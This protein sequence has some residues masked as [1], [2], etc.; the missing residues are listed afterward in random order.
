M[1]L[2]FNLFAG[3]SRSLAEVGENEGEGEGK[4]ESEGETDRGWDSIP[5]ASSSASGE[6]T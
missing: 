2:C 3:L 1:Y 6:L 5:S 4:G